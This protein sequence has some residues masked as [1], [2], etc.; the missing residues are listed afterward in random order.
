MSPTSTESLLNWT[1]A[2]YVL[3]FARDG[4]SLSN[5]KGSD[6]FLSIVNRTDTQ[7]TFFGVSSE[8]KTILAGVPI[9]LIT[10]MFGSS[11]WIA[12]TVS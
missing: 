5:L 8:P 9:S 1:I 3:H 4:L 11:L 2:N 10:Q 7:F 6:L 12:H